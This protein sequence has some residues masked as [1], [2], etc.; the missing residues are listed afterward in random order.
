MARSR[1]PLFI[2]F[3][4]F[5]CVTRHT[6]KDAR[7]LS[8]G[9][10]LGADAMSSGLP[11]SGPNFLAAGVAAPNKRS[12][13]HVHTRVGGFSLALCLGTRAVVLLVR[14]G[15]KTLAKR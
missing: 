5:L 11:A 13:H 3:L 10:A 2:L 4:F 7:T 9:P 8:R 15:K 12:A 1:P 6:C 14:R